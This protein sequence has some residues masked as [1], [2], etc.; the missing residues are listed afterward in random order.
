ME[1]PSVTLYVYQANKGM[2]RV[3]EQGRVAQPIVRKT[4]ELLPNRLTGRQVIQVVTVDYLAV[5]PVRI[6][7]LKL[8]ADD[9][10][11]QQRQ[12]ILPCI[13]QS[14][15]FNHPCSKSSYYL[16]KRPEGSMSACLLVQFRP[17]S[18]R[19]YTGNISNLK[20]YAEP[21]GRY[22]VRS[23]TVRLQAAPIQTFRRD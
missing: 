12:R 17:V 13:L 4:S 21:R 11:G 10:G 5:A 15:I 22:T 3:R 9:V 6:G 19:P 20:T 1:P 8:C 18:R 23:M 7:R 16:S 2:R 14:G